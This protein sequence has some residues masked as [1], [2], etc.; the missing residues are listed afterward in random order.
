MMMILAT[1]SVLMLKLKVNWK[2]LISEQDLESS[3][4]GREACG[5]FGHDTEWW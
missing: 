4:R 3:E 2:A 5:C 1:C